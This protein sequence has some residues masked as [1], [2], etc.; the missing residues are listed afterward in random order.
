MTRTTLRRIQSRAT[1]SAFGIGD[2]L[3]NTPVYYE[4]TSRKMAQFLERNGDIR[5]NAK[6]HAFALWQ[7][8]KSGVIKGAVAANITR[9][10]AKAF[11]GFDK[12]AAM[13]ERRNQTNEHIQ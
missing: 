6:T 7:K 1:Q 11:A 3:P 5:Q 4:E 2:D 10:H 8:I 12:Q 13:L 9:D